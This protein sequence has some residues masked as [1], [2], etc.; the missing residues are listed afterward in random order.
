MERPGVCPRGGGRVE[1]RI[2]P[3]RQVRGLRLTTRPKPLGRVTGFSAVAG[4]PDHIAKRQ[5]RRGEVR[6]RDRGLEADVRLEKWEGGPGSV[7]ALTFDEAPV[8]T[9]FFGLGAR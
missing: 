3:C 2:A 9:L 1:A 4:L 8:P 5:A 7:I 6:L